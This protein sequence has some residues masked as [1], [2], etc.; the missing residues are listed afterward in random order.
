MERYLSSAMR[1]TMAVA[2]SVLFGACG[3]E[4]DPASPSDDPAAYS[5]DA[6]AYD[7][8]VSDFRWVV[9]SAAL[10]A[11]TPI[12]ASNN[13]LDI[14]LFEGRLYLAWRTA[15]IH[16]ASPNARMYIVSSGDEG[17]TWQHEHTV[18]M[19]SDVREPRFA[20]IGG[21]L[22]FYFF[23]GGT[24]AIAFEPRAMW[25]TQRVG[26]GVWL[27][28]T[29]FGRPGEVLW[30]MKIRDGRILLSSYIGNHYQQG[31]SSIDVYLQTS[32]DGVT[33]RP[34]DPAVPIVYTGGVS[35]TSY[36]LDEDGALWAVTRNED[37]DS[38]G[39]GSQVC[40]APANTLAS[41]ECSPHSA[42]DRYDSP[43]LIRHGRDFY[44]IA[45]RD[46]GGPY[47]EG[48][49]SLPFED[50]RNMYQ[51]DYWTRPKRTA[52]YRLDTVARRVVH[53]MD[54]PSAGDTA[55]PAVRRTGPHTF[56]LANYT[57]PLD[58]PDRSWIHGQTSPQGTQIYFVTLRFVPQR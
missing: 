23:Q 1:R 36:E 17:V 49:D 43:K 48:K 35:E 39:F 30:D 51:F 46:I 3:L 57:S 37:G 2:F 5:V 22:H 55:Y 24:N 4:R 41:W 8:E 25:R 19:G 31:V 52:I 13:N 16:F 32:A 14:E 18:M 9:P 15:E 20:K 44:L 26:P 12:M 29:T 27:P 42:P 38:T 58:D 40:R 33:F 53:M 45:R 10:P 6:L 21:A 54:L 11:E 7:L 47:D 50:Q 28:E 56:L 34:V